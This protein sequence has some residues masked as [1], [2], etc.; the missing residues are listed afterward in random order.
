M[1]KTL[2][3]NF[4]DQMHDKTLKEGLTFAN[5]IELVDACTELR[6][7]ARDSGT[8]AIG[9]VNIPLDRIFANAD[10]SAPSKN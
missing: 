7:V 8:G 4:P 10:K 9:S 2:N 3:L 1:A 5:T 6:L